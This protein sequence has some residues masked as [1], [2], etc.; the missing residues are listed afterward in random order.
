LAPEV[1]AVILDCHGELTSNIEWEL[2]L[3]LTYCRP[4]KIIVA[5]SENTA[6]LAHNRSFH[7]VEVELRTLLASGKE[8]VS[9]ITYPQRVPLN[10]LTAHYEGIVRPAQRIIGVAAL[11]P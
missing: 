6:T 10:T 7:D 1:D 2:H 8:S 9:T 4:G 3:L 11:T 5:I